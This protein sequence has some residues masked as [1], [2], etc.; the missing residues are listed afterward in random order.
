MDG[1]REFGE[2]SARV[3]ALQENFLDFRAEMRRGLAELNEGVRDRL[4]VHSKRLGQLERWRSYI[5]GALV[6]LAALWTFIKG[7]LPILWTSRP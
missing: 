6:A 7:I 3:E 1:D 5:A 2:L 4:N